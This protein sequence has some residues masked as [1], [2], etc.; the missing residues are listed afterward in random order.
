M[1]QMSLNLCINSIYSG[2]A[3]CLFVF[4]RLQCSFFTARRIRLKI[5]PRDKESSQK[6]LGIY[7]E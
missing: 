5:A 2:D 7:L 4:G 6:I 1:Y 3:I